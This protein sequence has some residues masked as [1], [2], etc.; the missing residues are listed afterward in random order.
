[1]NRNLN[2]GLTE[3]LTQLEAE[4]ERNEL[5]QKFPEVVYN[6]ALAEDEDPADYYGFSIKA[7]RV[8]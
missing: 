5:T 8:G 2:E 1:M 3:S 4:F 7:V 6:G